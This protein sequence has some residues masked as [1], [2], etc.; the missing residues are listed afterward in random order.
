MQRAESTN[1]ESFC[2]RDSRDRRLPRSSPARRMRADSPPARCSSVSDERRVSLG[3]SQ[4]RPQTPDPGLCSHAHGE[5]RAFAHMRVCRALAQNLVRRSTCARCTQKRSSCIEDLPR[6]VDETSDAIPVDRAA[7]RAKKNR[8][9]GRAQATKAQ[10]LLVPTDAEHSQYQ[11][12]NP[13][14]DTNKRVL[15]AHLTFTPMSQVPT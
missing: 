1:A 4:P 8:T 15:R 9:E 3:A 2:E 13:D 7:N 6:R 5:R 10:R 11:N 12:A 14:S